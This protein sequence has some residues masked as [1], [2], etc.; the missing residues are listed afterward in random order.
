MSPHGATDDEVSL[1]ARL[2]PED[3]GLPSSE[4]RRVPG[5]RRED[6]AQLAGV[7]YAYCAR[8]EQGR[9]ETRCGRGVERLTGPTGRT[10]ARWA[11]GYAAG[12]P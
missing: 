2:N 5:L 6:L 9:G 10:F 4:R 1:R 12:F 3:V 7:P 11:V 8:A